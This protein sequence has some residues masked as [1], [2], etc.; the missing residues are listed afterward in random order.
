MGILII[1]FIIMMVVTVLF[2]KKSDTVEDLLVGDRNIPL[3]PSALSI[4]AT[5]IWAP[6]LLV[7]AEKSYTWGIPGLFW[8]LVPNILCLIIFSP[9]AEKIRHKMPNGYTLS[10][11]MKSIYGDRVEK[12]YQTQLLIITIL[13]TI[14]QLLAGGL[15]VSSITGVSFTVTTIALSIIAF[16]YSQFSGIKASIITDALQMIIMLLVCLVLVPMSIKV[17]GGLNT[18]KIGMNGITGEYG[19][20]LSLKGKEVFLAFGLSTAI[21]LI[22]GPFGD[23]SF[24]QRAF[25]IKKSEVKKSFILGAIFFAFVPLSMGIIGFVS[26]GIGMQPMNVGMVNVEFI[27]NYLPSIMFYPF[28]LAIISGLMS[29]V[30][31]NLCAITSIINDIKSGY[32]LNDGKLTM[33]ILLI[34]SVLGA[35]MPGLTVTK[36]FM[37]YG[38]VRASTLFT[39]ILTLNDVKLNSS[40][41]AIGIT[42]SLIIGLPIFIYGTLNEINSLIV[43]GSLATA[44][45]SGIVALTHTKL[46][47]GNYAWKKEIDKKQ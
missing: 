45:I 32:S 33:A 18:V 46:R 29:T 6:A 13:S 3:I 40:G 15:L 36:L 41:V 47:G 17:G 2:T 20:L 42:A 26:A 25:S 27:Q 44:L 43:L 4:A 8:F 16:S 9:Y 23:Q 14:V 12:L 34:V 19:N 24:W 1:Y 21:G 5:W 11:Y 28:V 35:N 7:A 37:I 31:S 30:D 38:T 39:T 10:G 22:S